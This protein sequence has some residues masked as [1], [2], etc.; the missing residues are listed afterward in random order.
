MGWYTTYVQ[1]CVFLMTA[2]LCVFI[3]LNLV[4]AILYL[5]QADKNVQEI[6]AYYRGENDARRRSEEKRNL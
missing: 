1:P 3:I 5:R 2:V 6:R 4:R